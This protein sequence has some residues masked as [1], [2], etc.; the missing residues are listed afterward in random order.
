MRASY[1]KYEG[2]VFNMRGSYL[3]RKRVQIRE[4]DPFADPLLQNDPFADPNADP[5]GLK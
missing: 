5:P 1:L 3:K 4:T 2:V